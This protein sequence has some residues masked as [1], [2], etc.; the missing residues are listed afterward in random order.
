MNIFR[1]SIRSALLVS[2]CLIAPSSLWAEEGVALDNDSIE[3]VIVT[4]N[5][6]E[7]S[8]S[9]VGSSVSVITASDLE[10]GQYAYT[11][12][13]LQTMPGVSINQTGSFGGVA[14]VR[15]RGA[16]SGH[17]MV[18]IDGIQVNDTASPAGAYD[19]A[20]LDPY[21]VERIEVL[22]GPQSIL[23]GSDAIGGV[24]NIISKSGQDGFGA[25]AFIE[26]GSF[27]TFRGGANIFGGTEQ[28]GYNLS[29]ST[30]TSA[31][32]SAAD[33]A[34]GNSE[35]DGYENLSF[36]GKATLKLSPA[37][38]AEVIARYS[39]SQNDYDGFGPADADNVVNSEELLLAGRL[40]FEAFEDRLVQKLSL[41]KST[42]DRQDISTFGE[43]NTRGSRLNVDY[44]A[45]FEASK[46][47]GLTVGAQHEET[48]FETVSPW[49][50]QP[51]TG[52][53]MDSLF[54]EVGFNSGNG[55]ILSAGLRYDDHETFGST[56][57][58]RVTAS[59]AISDSGTRLIAN[60]GQ[61]FKAPTIFQ[62]TY[63][64][65]EGVNLSLKPEEANAWEVGV[66]QDLL[67]GRLVLGAT[68][69]NQHTKDL[70]TFVW[71]QGY[72]NLD[73]TRAQG[74]EL[75]VEAELTDK[76]RFNGN[77][78]YTDAKDETT[79]E[80]LIAQPKDMAFASLVWEAAPK[81]LGT[82]NLVYNGA[83]IAYGGAK[84]DGWTRVDVKITMEAYEGIELYGRID[85]LF[86]KQYQQVSGFGTPGFSVFG[87]VRAKF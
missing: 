23:Y 24:V 9:E 29:A 11:V 47:I 55:L 65:L 2:S 52:F 72:I 58:G 32:I 77:Y 69:F 8:L 82:L 17:T 85:N 53:S 16:S 19:F 50:E 83:E 73:K 27:S 14:S 13:A 45:S 20:S 21:G 36:S 71:P 5:R 54:G 41:E 59:Y 28:I 25:Q 34:D 64:G 87:G 1:H 6:R 46:M 4:V 84:L 57:N 35:K 70:I 40:R 75:R 78:T 7:Q 30:I 22:R 43:T 66:E 86:N 68:Y 76:I 10:L 15:I 79:G 38:Q 67:D 63:V 39:D 12:D 81:V 51:S 3:E 48:K 26:G 49:G 60:W 37:F 61:G 56:T 42:L 18:L 74:A 80:T 33:E 62:L 44:L 31:G